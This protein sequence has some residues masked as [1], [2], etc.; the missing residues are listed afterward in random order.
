MPRVLPSG[1]RLTLAWNPE[2][3]R[4]MALAIILIAGA[5]GVVAPAASQDRDAGGVRAPTVELE[6][7]RAVYVLN[8][9]HFCH[10]VDLTRAQMGAAS[11]L[12]SPLVGADVQGNAIGVIVRAGIPNLQTSM[13]GYPDLTDAEIRDLAAY[14]HYL[15]QV[16]RRKALLAL[17]DTPGDAARGEAYFAVT[18]VECHSVTGDLQGLAGRYPWRP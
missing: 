1:A 2:A 17:A 14:I 7:G 13:P 4:R 11:L 9:C 12:Q 5:A 18:C 3:G 15:R 8:T 10:G 6:R 16:G